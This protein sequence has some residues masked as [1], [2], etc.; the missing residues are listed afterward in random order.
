MAAITNSNLTVLNT[1]FSKIFQDG[2]SS[3][4]PVYKNIATEVNSTSASNTYGWLGE[5]PEMAEWIGTRSLKDFKTHNYAIVNKL[6]ESSISVKR[7]DIEDDNVGIYA[8]LFSALGKRAAQNPDT[9]VFNLLINGTTE[10]CFDGVPFFSNNH[11]VYPNSDGTGKKKDASNLQ[12][13][14]APAWYLL[15]TS[16]ALKPLIFQSREKAELTAMNKTDD[17]AVFM[18]DKFRYG[19][20]ARHNAGYGFWQMAYVSKAELNAV[21]FNKAVSAMM[22]QQADGG[23]YLGIKPTLLI[24]PPQLRAKALEIVKSERLAN[25]ET[26][27]NQGLVELLVTPFVQDFTSILGQ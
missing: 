6:F 9:I 7:T 24:V 15:D 4:E 8:P 25:G 17:E 12:S 3:I 23:R 14:T 10:L 11:P 13:G 26:N 16:Q 1:A 21:N 22:S 2:L 5:M 18:E 20:R 19:V 27:V